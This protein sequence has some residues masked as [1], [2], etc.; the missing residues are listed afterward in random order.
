MAAEGHGRRSKRH[1][2]AADLGY[3]AISRGRYAE[4]EASFKKLIA[5]DPGSAEARADLGEIYLVGLKKPKAA[6]EAY[7]AAIAR[8]GK[9]VRAYLG[10]RV[11]W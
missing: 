6:E 9:Y 8:D 5:L 1:R 3:A 11:H 7:R 10:W 2:G 4:A